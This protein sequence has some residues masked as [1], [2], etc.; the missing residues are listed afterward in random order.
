MAF[1][2]NDIKEVSEI[3]RE[4]SSS[5]PSGYESQETKQTAGQSWQKLPESNREIGI[6]KNK[7]F[8]PMTNFSVR[9]MGYVVDDSTLTSA[10][11]FLFRIIPKDTVQCNVGR[12]TR[13]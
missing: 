7:L 10:H 13:I 12:N 6:M 4:L 1:T 2:Q 3:V 5:Q 9:C 11:G 8:V